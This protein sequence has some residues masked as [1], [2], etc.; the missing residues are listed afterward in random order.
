MPGGLWFRFWIK[1]FCVF[2][3]S[4]GIQQGTRLYVGHDFN[5]ISPSVAGLVGLATYW[6][7]L[8]DSSPKQEAV[9]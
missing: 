3:L 2:V 1:S 8:F 6:S 9:K 4:T 5:W 7:G